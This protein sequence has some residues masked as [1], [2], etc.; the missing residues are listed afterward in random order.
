MVVG[1]SKKKPFLFL[2]DRIKSRM[3]SWTRRLVSWVGRKVLIKAVAQVI[4]T[5][6]MSIFK[7]LQE[8]CHS[9]QATINRFWWGHKQE[10]RKILWLSASK[11]CLKKEDGGIR[12][13][14]I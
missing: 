8:L 9:I 14:D 2:V 12:F 10:E 3:S 6:S 11:L 5:Y 4:P 1:R 7:L 13:R